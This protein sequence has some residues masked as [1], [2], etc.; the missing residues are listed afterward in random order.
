M[1]PKHR[2]QAV[3]RLATVSAMLIA[4]IS[5][6]VGCERTEYKRF[7]YIVGFSLLFGAIVLY[8]FG[9]IAWAQAKG[10]PTSIPSGI[11]AACI[12]FM[13][14]IPVIPFFIMFIVLPTILFVM[15]DRAVRD[16][17]DEGRKWL[18]KVMKYLCIDSAALFCLCFLGYEIF[19]DSI[20]KPF[21]IVAVLSL[22][23]ALLSG[24]VWVL[25]L[26]FSSVKRNKAPH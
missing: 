23:C 17:S 16:H 15:K 13:F 3:V 12:V 25:I 5:I 26:C 19:P 2:Q 20:P 10:L 14:C 1:I 21:G 18:R 7:G 4:A 8:I 22:F 6:T 11:I 24:L 9:C